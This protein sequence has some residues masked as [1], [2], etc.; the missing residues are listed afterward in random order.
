MRCTEEAHVSAFNSHH[1]QTCR[2]PTCASAAQ[3]ACCCVTSRCTSSCD[4]R[5]VSRNAIFDR[6][7]RVYATHHS[8]STSRDDCGMNDEVR[9][10]L[11][12]IGK[13]STEL[14]GRLTEVR[15]RHAPFRLETSISLQLCPWRSHMRFIV[16]SS[17]RGCPIHRFKGGL[18][19]RP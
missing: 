18:V 1:P 10:A 16:V 7:A 12:A 4:E 11:D 19:W 9:N 3:L 8:Q 14:A 17:S 13:S 5:R 15:R 2:L 6:C